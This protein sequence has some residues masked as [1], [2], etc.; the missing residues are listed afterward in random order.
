MSNFN[1]YKIK[2]NVCYVECL[3]SNK[4]PKGTFMIDTKDLPS[5]SM[6][7]WCITNKGYIYN[8]YF[9]KL[10][11]VLMRPGKGL[12]VDHIDRNKLN[13]TRNNLRVTTHIRNNYNKGLSKRNKSGVV[14]VSYASKVGKWK[15][16][17]KYKLKS[18][19]LSYFNSKEEA[20][21]V[22]KNS[23]KEFYN[24]AL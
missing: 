15:A 7:R 11:G 22:R 24:K 2:G 21:K 5:I 4:I 6:C 14:G 10:H 1:K 19:N 20:I 23:E 8:S 9:G 3:D 17:I 16:G 13:N 18:Y 12:T